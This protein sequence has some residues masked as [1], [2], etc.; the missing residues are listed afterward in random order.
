MFLRPDGFIEIFVQN[1]HKCEA[2]VLFVL[3]GSQL[4]LEMALG[5]EILQVVDKVI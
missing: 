1:C 5:T 4:D 3:V 2:S